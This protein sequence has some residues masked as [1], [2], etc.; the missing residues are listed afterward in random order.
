M[1]K[2]P[3]QPVGGGKPGTA[4]LPLEHCQLLTKGEIFNQQTL[5]RAKQPK[6]GANPSRKMLNMPSNS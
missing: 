3:E 1:K 5:T 4:A 6:E 2:Q